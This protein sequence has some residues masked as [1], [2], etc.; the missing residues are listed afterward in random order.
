MFFGALEM[1]SVRCLGLRALVI[2]NWAWWRPVLCD[3]CEG[4]PG[5]GCGCEGEAKGVLWVWV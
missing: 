1:V 3:V 4:W 2:L 5:R